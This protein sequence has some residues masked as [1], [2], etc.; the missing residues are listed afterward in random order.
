MILETINIYKY[1][2]VLNDYG[3]VIITMNG[4]KYKLK[5]YDFLLISSSFL[6]LNYE[7]DKLKNCLSSYT[8]EK[9]NLFGSNYRKRSLSFVL[10]NTNTIHFSFNNY[11][12]VIDIS[13]IGEITEKIYDFYNFYYSHENID[14]KKLHA[15]Y[16]EHM[17]AIDLPFISQIR[18]N[19]FNIEDIKIFSKTIKNGIP[20]KDSRYYLSLKDKDY[21][22]IVNE[23]TNSLNEN[24]NERLKIILNEARKK[25]YPNNNEYIISYNNDLIIR[26]GERRI[27]CLYFLYGNINISVLNIEFIKNYYSFRLFYLNKSKVT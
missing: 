16:L 18:L 20:I 19:K 9:I 5:E 14:Y 2:P 7:L 10:I 25:T 11:T 22:P 17:L 4:V 13:F 6:R 15:V 8:N 12:F 26:D 21:T 27:S 3:I 1:I 23:A 24:T